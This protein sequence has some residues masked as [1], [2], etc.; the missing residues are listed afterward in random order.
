MIKKV[1]PVIAL[2][3]VIAVGAL[4]YA[5][6]RTPE[7]ASA[8]IEA[9]PVVVENEAAPAADSEAA[10]PEVETEVEEAATPAETEAVA[11]SDEVEPDAAPAEAGESAVAE[12]G[13]AIFEIVSARSEVV[14]DA[15]IPLPRILFWRDKGH[16]GRGYPLDMLGTDLTQ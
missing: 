8:P 7:E 14:I 10:A 2:L 11:Q 4:A 12:S 16:L 9:I 3:I 6:L 13:S 15:T 5:F 1:L